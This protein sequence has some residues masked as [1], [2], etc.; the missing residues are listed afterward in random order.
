MYDAFVDKETEE[1]FKITP[2]ISID[3][4]IMEKSDKVATIPMDCGWNDLG[5]FDSFYD[6]FDKDRN[7]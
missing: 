7:K 1:A 5:S 3:Y 2:K 6:I 4:G